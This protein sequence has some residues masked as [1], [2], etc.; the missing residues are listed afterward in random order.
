MRVVSKQFS[1]ISQKAISRQIAAS[2]YRVV[3]DFSAVDPRKI[4][5]EWFWLRSGFRFAGHRCVDV[6]EL[7]S[8]GRLKFQRKD[9]IAGGDV[10]LVRE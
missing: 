4:C 7:K 6:R 3:G 5:L 8:C 1:V 10:Y 2:K 9:Y